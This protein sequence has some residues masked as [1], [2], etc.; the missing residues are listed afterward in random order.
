MLKATIN[1]ID[2]KKNKYEIVESDLKIV[3]L[4]RKKKKKEEKEF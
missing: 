1:Q 3:W 2:K 4:F